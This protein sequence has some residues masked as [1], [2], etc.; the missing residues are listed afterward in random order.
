MITTKDTA[1]YICPPVE[2]TYPAVVVFD[3]SNFP[4][5][6]ISAHDSPIQAISSTLDFFTEIV[7]PPIVS[8]SSYST[9]IVPVSPS[10]VHVLS[11]HPMVTRR[12]VGVIK[13]NPKYALQCLADDNRSSAENHN[14]LNVSS[15]PRWSPTERNICLIVAGYS[16][17]MLATHA[18]F[19]KASERSLL[20]ELQRGGIILLPCLLRVY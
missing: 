9:E 4:L 17:A 16:Q 6:Q 10:P 12:Q 18:G 20:Q 15:L 11:Q 14:L 2:Y 19:G 5:Q 3:E 8:D 1:V 7:D 13:P